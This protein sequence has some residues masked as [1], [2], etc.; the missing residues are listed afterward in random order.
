[1]SDS[2]PPLEQYVC[3]F[4]PDHLTGRSFISLLTQPYFM[5]LPLKYHP[6]TFRQFGC[7]RI[8]YL[9][10]RSFIN[11]LTLVYFMSSRSDTGCQP[12]KTWKA[13]AFRFSRLDTR[14]L[15]SFGQALDLLVTVSSM[16]YHTSTP[17]LSTLSSSRGLTGFLQGYLILRGASRLDAFSVYPF[18][19]RPPCPGPGGPAGAPAVRPARSS[20]TKASS[21]QISCACAG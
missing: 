3:R 8:L 10:G 1:M 19:T 5:S 18:R 6:Y 7:C 15:H 12:G 4:T 9:T 2:C 13:S 20:R 21:F 16:C 17:A 11:S 14:R